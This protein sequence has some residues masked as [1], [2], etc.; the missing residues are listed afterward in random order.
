MCRETI[1]VH[2]LDDARNA[3]EVEQYLLG[4]QYIDDVSADFLHDRVTI[5]YDEDMAS[6]T[7]VL[8]E[9]EHSGC[10]PQENV[11]G[12]LDQLKLRLTGRS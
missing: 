4:L 12:V 9:L 8:K 5:V 10:T 3:Y 6:H 7:D 11:S 2:G 1:N